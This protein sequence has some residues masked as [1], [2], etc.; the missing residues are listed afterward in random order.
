MQIS[1]AM[2]SK[3]QLLGRENKEEIKRFNKNVNSK[4]YSMHQ[5]LQN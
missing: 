1:K 2:H 5:Y 3:M 4:I